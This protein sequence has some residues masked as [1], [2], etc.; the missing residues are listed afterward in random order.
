MRIRAA[1]SSAASPQTIRPRRGAAAT[2]STARCR[3]FASAARIHIRGC[4]ARRTPGPWPRPVACSARGPPGW[5]SRPSTISSTRSC[6]SSIWSVRS[7]RD[8]KRHERKLPTGLRE[9]PGDPRP[10]R[11]ARGL[12][13]GI[14]FRSGR[15]PTTRRSRSWRDSGADRRPCPSASQCDR[16]EAEAVRPPEST[17]GTP[18]DPRCEARRSPSRRSPRRPS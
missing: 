10:G 1:S 11:F 17:S 15:F 2:R 7:R 13:D 3:I 18:R 6:G 8:R 12:R 16:P 4:S 14:F 5:S 9:L